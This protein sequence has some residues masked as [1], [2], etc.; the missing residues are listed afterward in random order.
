MT[1]QQ[2]WEMPR[3]L[4]QQTVRVNQ[5]S[6]P[7]RPSPSLESTASSTPFTMV[8]GTSV[9]LR[10][11]FVFCEVIFVSPWRSVF[12]ITTAFFPLISFLQHPRCVWPD[13]QPPPRCS[14]R[15]RKSRS[16]RTSS[17]RSGLLGPRPIQRRQRPTWRP[18]NMHTPHK[19]TCLELA[20]WT[21][22]TK[23]KWTKK[24]NTTS[25]T[26]DHARQTCSW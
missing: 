18:C 7:S 24:L 4:W 19:Y 13:R 11:T 22:Q 15:D 8:H 10:T 6:L 25:L 1:S 20:L 16:T 21:C 17:F 23:R 12:R 26:F 9:P 2:T 14:W 3:M 5:V